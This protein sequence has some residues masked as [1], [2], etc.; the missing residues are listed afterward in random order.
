LKFYG[1]GFSGFADAAGMD[2]PTNVL[3]RRITSA[4]CR[5]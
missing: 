2:D 5:N 1:K 4:T 3:L